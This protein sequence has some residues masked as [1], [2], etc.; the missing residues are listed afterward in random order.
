[1]QLLLG[2][3]AGDQALKVFKPAA[4]EVVLKKCVSAIQKKMALAG[5]LQK[6]FVD[7][8]RLKLSSVTVGAVGRW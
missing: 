8:V 5:T 6:P 4:V 3:G 2:C 1:M 7:L